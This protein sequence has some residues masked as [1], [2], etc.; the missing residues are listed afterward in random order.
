[1][2]VCSKSFRV[3]YAQLY[4]EHTKVASGPRVKTYAIKRIVRVQR[5]N[6]STRT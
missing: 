6:I 3:Y 5:K 4:L 2:R 1:M